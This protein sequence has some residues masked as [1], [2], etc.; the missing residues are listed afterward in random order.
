MAKG[1]ADKIE[2]ALNAG[3]AKFMANTQSKLSASSP[4]D[5]GRLASSW[6]PGYGSPDR[7]TRPEDWAEPGA[8]RVVVEPVKTQEVSVRNT[9]YISN[10]LPYA[11]RAAMDP[12]YVGRRGG[13]SGDW[14]SRVVNALPQDAEKQIKSELR[15]LR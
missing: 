11:E 8:N 10:S 12:G 6:M 4:I 14:F 9:N 13:G 1:L 5:T 7:E 3:V 2:D 15:K